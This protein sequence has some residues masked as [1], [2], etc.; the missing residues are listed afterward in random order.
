MFLKNLRNRIE[1]IYTNIKVALDKAHTERAVLEAKLDV[2]TQAT[3]SAFRDVNNR[4]DESDYKVAK[5]LEA[6][7]VTVHKLANLTHGLINQE[8]LKANET[9]EPV[10]EEPVAE[11]TEDTQVSMV[12]TKRVRP[13]YTEE[14]DN[15]LVQLRLET[16]DW[17]RITDSLN[18][19]FASNRAPQNVKRHFDLY[20]TEKYE[21]AKALQNGGEKTTNRKPAALSDQNL[22]NRVLVL[23]FKN[24]SYNNIA[25]EVGLTFGQVQSYLRQRGIT[26]DNFARE[27]AVYGDE[28]R[29]NVRWDKQE[30][31]DL[32]SY[33]DNYKF[34][35]CVIATIL[36]RSVD[37]VTNE[38]RNQGYSLKNGLFYKKNYEDAV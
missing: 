19:K 4:F 16:D 6:L 11:T 32:V 15:A 20:L 8:A 9:E 3:E 28:D 29:T 38:A 5:K 27:F 13:E 25:R 14:Q 17:K 35:P 24:V 31:S 12:K 37:A 33:I 2:M 1:W 7:E 23:F 21:A 26:K 22:L 34:A 30:K 36:S 10:A 18:E